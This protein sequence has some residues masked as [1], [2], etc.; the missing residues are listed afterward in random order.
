MASSGRIRL[1]PLVLLLLVLAAGV[2]GYMLFWDRTAPV[3]ELAPLTVYVSKNMEFT[4]KA[5]DTKSGVRSMAV[6]VTAGGESWDIAS[7]VFP[8]KPQSAEL[9]FSLEALPLTDGEIEIEVTAVDGSYAGFG[10]GNTVVISRS[11]TLDTQPPR[12]GI[13]SGAM[14]VTR[15]GSGAVSFSL[16]EEPALVGVRAGDYFFPAYK[17]ENGNWSCI[18]GF[19]YT[20]DTADYKPLLIATDPAGNESV[21]TLGVNARARQFKEDTI[22]LPQSFLDNKMPEF[23]QDF[24]DKSGNLEIFLAVNSEM[25]TANRASLIEIGQKKTSPTPLWKGD[26]LRMPGATMAGFAER[27]SYIYEGQTVDEQTHLGVDIASTQRADVPSANNGIVIYTGNMGI[28][29]NCVIVDHGLGLMTLYAHLSEIGVD[30]NAE[31]A[32]GQILGKTGV[33]GLAGGDHLH[34]GVLVSGLPVTPIEW[35]DAHWIRNNVGDRLP[36]VM[37]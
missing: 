2:G 9:P 33:T 25:R 34:F 16:N 11:H 28:Y 32:R 14:N 10:A 30:T 18:F 15:G 37:E 22:N 17:Q 19:P 12:I 26:F 21:V 35:W 36:G 6:R 20:M 5:E 4:A 23:A 31:V 24:P 27:R 7:Q 1:F 8:S 29:G 13:T 3:A